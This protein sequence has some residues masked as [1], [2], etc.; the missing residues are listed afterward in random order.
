MFRIQR[1]GVR[2]VFITWPLSVTQ[3]V[4]KS[5]FFAA[6]RV[7]VNSVVYSFG[8]FGYY[9]FACFVRLC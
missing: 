6:L 2:R 9:F 5:S 1:F 8:N 3:V 4:C 7:R